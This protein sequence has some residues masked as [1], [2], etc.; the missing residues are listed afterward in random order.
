MLNHTQG[1]FT[2]RKGWCVSRR[3]WAL[4]G[5]VILSSS[6]LS[7]Q[8]Q[9]EGARA[10]IRKQITEKSLPSVAVAV[11]QHGK[12]LWE[13]GFGWANREERIRATENSMYSLASVSK[14][15]TAT[16][17]MTLVQAGRIDLDK[18]IN[19][20]L[21]DA[22][23]RARIG[24]ANA[25]TVRRVANHSSGLPL[26]YQFFFSNVPFEKPSEDETIL[27]YGNLVTIPGEFFQYSN[28]GYGILGYVLSRMS[29]ESYV[30]FMRQAVF[31]KLGLTHTSVGVGPGLE[32]FQ[33]I[34]YDESGAPIPFYDF[35][36]PGASAVFSSA[37]DLV[38]FG[39]FHL[40][41]HVKG[42]SQILSDASIDQMQQA[43]MRTSPDLQGEGGGYGIGWFM[44]DKP[45][46]YHVVE[47]TGGMPGVST[48]LMLVPSED[49]AVAVLENS[50]SD[51]LR[52]IANQI[53]KALLPKWQ[54][55]SEE[56]E[57]SRKAF[58]PG[59]LLGTWK[60]TLHT[61][62]R[63][64]PAAMVVLPSGDVHFQI[65]DELDSLVNKVRFHDGWFSGKAWGDVQTDDAARHRVDTLSFS[66]KLR[67]TV[68]NGA[69]SAQK[70][71]ADPVAL[72]QWLELKTQK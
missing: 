57:V 33:A 32:K 29:G 35:D 65:A 45:G 6:S 31:V 20:Y 11:A 37:H 58:E 12:I 24:D 17:L 34:R 53:I 18:P 64:L 39:M 43:T 62:Q 21:G 46:G 68:L 2:K 60:G 26:H 47:H 44:E 13:E 36:H 16:G 51:T 23:L 70:G 8:D 41:D 49:L 48:I 14:P 38:S 22:K 5:I 42:Q 54:V 67:G 3:F 19:D 61:Y 40:K 15:F 63:D 71:G 9:F 55:P 4:V 50:S 66:L 28:L 56:P 27:R 69:V 10:F 59:D 1:F 25:A 7:A 30:A 52:P 72:T